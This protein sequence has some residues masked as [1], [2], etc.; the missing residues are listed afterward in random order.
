MGLN[1]YPLARR[2]E[3]RKKKYLSPFDN[4][5]VRFYYVDSG[6]SRLLNSI[7][8]YRIKIINNYYLTKFS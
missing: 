2:K 8:I 5:R 4:F 6:P 3:E 7:S 1:I